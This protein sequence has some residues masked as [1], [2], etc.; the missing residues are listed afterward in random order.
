MIDFN[1]VDSTIGKRTIKLT[2]VQV[3]PSFDGKRQSGDVEIQSNGLRY[4]STMKS[5]QKIG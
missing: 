3:R 5:D 4:Q 2:D 1:D